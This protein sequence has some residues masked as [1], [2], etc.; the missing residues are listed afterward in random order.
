MKKKLLYISILLYVLTLGSKVLGFI[1][2]AA[3]AY[4]Y[5]AGTITDAYLFS[6]NIMTTIFSVFTGALNMGYISVMASKK[7][8]NG[9]L[10]SLLKLLSIILIGISTILF[11][12]APII[13]RTCAS[14]FDIESVNLSTSMLRIMI[15]FG[16][17][18]IILYLLSADLESKEVFWQIGVYGIIGNVVLILSIVLSNGSYRILALGYGLSLL[19]QAIFVYILSK[20]KGFKYV[21]NVRIKDEDLKKIIIVSMP[22]LFIEFFTNAITLVDKFFASSFST[23]IITDIN[24]ASRIVTMVLTFFVSVISRI[25]MPIY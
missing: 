17:F 21:F 4:Q 22:L 18:Q 20:K 1:K 8:H 24:Y 12:F 25:I 23:G 11:V 6:Q 2:E 9:T 10:S 16:I 5:G 3:L 15:P 14:G 19:I 7:D 13:V